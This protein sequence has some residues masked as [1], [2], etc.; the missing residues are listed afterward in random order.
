MSFKLLDENLRAAIDLITEAAL[1]PRPLMRSIG[2]I[3]VE[4]SQARFATRTAPDGTP[5]V[6]RKPI[7]VIRG[8]GADAVVE[9]AT[10]PLMNRTSSLRD[11]IVWQETSDGGVEISSSLPYAR[12]HNQGGRTKP[13]VIKPR[14]RGVLRFANGGTIYFAKA[15]NHPGSVIP[16][17]EFLGVSSAAQDRILDRASEYLE[18]AGTRRSS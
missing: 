6:P 8:R 2:A 17:R 12:I 14:L 18:I 10:H 13:H 7:F 16:Q 5:W 9:T 15:V 4:D 1:R 3:V 11:S